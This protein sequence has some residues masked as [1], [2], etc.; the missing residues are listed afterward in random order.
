MKTYNSDMYIGWLMKSFGQMFDFAVNSC[1][2]DGDEFW[3]MLICSGIA[4]QIEEGN[5][6]YTSGKSGIE[7]VYDVADAVQID[8][9]PRDTNTEGRTIAYW[10]G[11]ALIQY[12]RETELSFKAIHRIIAYAD[13]VNMYSTLHEADV[14][15][16]IDVINAIRQRRTTNL[17]QKRESMKISQSQLSYSTGVSIKTIQAYEQRL[18]DINQGKYDT[19]QKLAKG[20]KCDIEELLEK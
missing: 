17:K 11:W 7:M 12:Q 19:L 3:N 5:P 9:A 15:K 2:L 6:K 16:V 1:E 8:I 10:C 13:L 14:S 18:K 20:L 4:K